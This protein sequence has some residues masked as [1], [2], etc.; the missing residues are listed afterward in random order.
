LRHTWQTALRPGQATLPEVADALAVTS[1]LVAL[2]S[3]AS[4]A[5]VV[6]LAFFR[7]G[8]TIGGSIT[9]SLILLGKAFRERWRAT[10][11]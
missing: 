7:R 8:F 2:A 5:F 9:V 1:L 10:R 11:R 3:L 4:L 6:D